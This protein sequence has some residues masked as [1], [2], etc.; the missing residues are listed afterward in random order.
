M[1]VVDLAEL[2]RRYAH[3]SAMLSLLH[4][5][6]PADIVTGMLPRLFLTCVTSER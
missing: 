2:E 6:I 3:V 4:A 5:G 1:H